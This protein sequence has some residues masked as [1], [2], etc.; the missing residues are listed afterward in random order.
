MAKKNKPR[1]LS[2]ADLLSIA[3]QLGRA[4]RGASFQQ[5]YSDGN[6]TFRQRYSDGPQAFTAV[7]RFKKEERKGNERQ[8]PAAGVGGKHQ[9]R[10][11]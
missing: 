4:F 3:R 6:P 10:A 7:S 1:R 5:R 9:C 11:R 8:Q 2:D